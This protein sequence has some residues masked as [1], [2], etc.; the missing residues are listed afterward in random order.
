M[1]TCTFQLGSGR[2][3]FA[4][5]FYRFSRSRLAMEQNIS[6]MV[7]VRRGAEP[8]ARTAARPLDLSRS[9]SAAFRSRRAC[10]TRGGAWRAGSSV[11]WC[12][13]RASSPVQRRAIRPGNEYSTAWLVPRRYDGDAAASRRGARGVRTPGLRD[14]RARAPVGGGDPRPH[15]PRGFQD[16]FGSCSRHDRPQ[17]VWGAI[18]GVRA[19]AFV[20]LGDVI[21]ADGKLEN[22]TRARTSGTTRTPPPSPP[23]TPTQTTPPYAR[24]PACWEPGTTMIS[25]TTTLVASGRRRSSRSA[26]SWISSASPIR[27]R[28]TTARACTSPTP[29]AASARNG[30]RSARLVLLDCRYHMSR[31]DG[32]LLGEDQW[33]WFERIMT[34]ET[35]EDNTDVDPVD[36][37]IIGSSIQVH[38]D[39][40]RMLEGI[41]HGVESWGQFPEGEEATD[42]SGGAIP[43]ALGVPLRGRAPRRGGHLPRSDANSRTSSWSSP[44]AE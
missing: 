28:D 26:S 37:T 31:E 29:S 8:R 35:V 38:A 7:T 27:P 5:P 6:V 30:D 10:V 19:D 17:D 2:F 39:T 20:W 13:G 40:Q 23:R 12:L 9:S 15:W 33:R 34:G 25:A 3:I 18:R 1:K 42:G 22:G 21:Y 14:E 32:V 24:R 4:A 11:R 36:V 16:A 44:A 43:K 41:A